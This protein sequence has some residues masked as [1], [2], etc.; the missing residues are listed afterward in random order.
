MAQLLFGKGRGAYLRMMPANTGREAA[1][2]FDTFRQIV[3]GDLHI[4]EI[5][6]PKR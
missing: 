6:R 2:L 1:R 3:A 5:K 4:Q